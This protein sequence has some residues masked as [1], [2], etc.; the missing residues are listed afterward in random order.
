MYLAVVTVVFGQAVAFASWKLALLAV[1]LWSLF[2]GVVVVLEEP[3][4][5]SR[6]GTLY[7]AYC[8]AVPRWLRAPGRRRPPR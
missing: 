5:R 2:H 8:R 4:L 1:A 6:Y 3:H 7:E